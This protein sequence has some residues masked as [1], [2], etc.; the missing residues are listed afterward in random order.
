MTSDSDYTHELYSSCCNA[1]TPA[2]R[3]QDHGR[4][5]LAERIDLNFGALDRLLA[6]GLLNEVEY[7][8]VKASKS[9]II[10]YKKLSEY[11]EL[12]WNRSTCADYDVF[13]TARFAKQQHLVNYAQ[14]SG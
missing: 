8:D 5:L 6:N 7:N 11:T 10:G 14:N 2:I 13:L 4:R 9:S 3:I 1:S 12:A